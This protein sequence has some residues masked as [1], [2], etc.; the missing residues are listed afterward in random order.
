ME[1]PL[2]DLQEVRK[3]FGPVEVLKGDTMQVIP[4]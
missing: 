3:A 4:G 2:I 1:T